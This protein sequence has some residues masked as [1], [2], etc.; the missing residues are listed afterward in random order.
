MT[1][2]QAAIG[3]IQLRRMDEWTVARNRNADAIADALVPFARPDGAVRIPEFRACNQI[4]GE[5]DTGSSHARYKYYVYIRPEALSEGWSRDRIVREIAASGVPCFQGSC[6]EIYLERAFEGTRWRPERSLPV[7]R[8]LGETSLM[9]LV[10]PTLAARE[11]E[12]TGDAIREVL[13][14]AEL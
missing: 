2:M 10:H 5:Q 6:S 8:E 7:A 12:Q 13:A 4:G 9:F 14:Q 1:E 3:R 11:M